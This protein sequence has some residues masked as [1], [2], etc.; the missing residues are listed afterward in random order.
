M[1][2]FQFIVRLLALSPLLAV[3]QFSPLQ[4]QTLITDY[5]L[6]AGNGTVPGATSAVPVAPG[7]AV[8]LSSSTSIPSGRVGSYVL[9]KTT[10]NSSVTG[11]IHSGG[12]VELAN[13]NTVGGSIT[14]ANN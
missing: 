12:K 8:Q 9:F 2:H 4:A 3:M 7:Y 6:Y 10:G 13:S 5:V 14:A 11:S 1:K